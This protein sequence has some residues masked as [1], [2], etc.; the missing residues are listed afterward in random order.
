MTSH[1][2]RK[3]HC[4]DE[5]ILWSSHPISEFWV[6]SFLCPRSLASK[7]TVFRNI[8]DWPSICTRAN[9]VT[10]NDLGKWI[11]WILWGLII[12]PQLQTDY[13]KTALMFHRV[14]CNITKSSLRLHVLPDGLCKL[15]D[16]CSEP[17]TCSKL[18]VTCHFTWRF[19]VPITLSRCLF[20]KKMSRYLGYGYHSSTHRC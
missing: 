5:T 18:H 10:L 2:H 12:A 20:M 7:S 17:I 6:L 1:Q 4:W 11:T 16:P 3:S 14:Y 8:C 13:N 9:E 15:L 19:F